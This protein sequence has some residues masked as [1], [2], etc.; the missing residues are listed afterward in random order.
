VHTGDSDSAIAVARVRGVRFRRRGVCPRHDVWCSKV[1][2]EATVNKKWGL[3]VGRV[4]QQEAM[5]GGISEDNIM[6]CL[7][8]GACAGAM[9]EDVCFVCNARWVVCMHR[10]FGAC[11]LAIRDVLG[12]TRSPQSVISHWSRGSGC[13]AGHPGLH[14]M[15]WHSHASAY[16]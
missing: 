2:F 5:Q 10:A 8:S 3:A 13:D 4:S 9:E 14:G 16:G 7:P 1:V 6:E 11:D 12:S 15:M